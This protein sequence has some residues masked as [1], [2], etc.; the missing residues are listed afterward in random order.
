MQ[1]LF[2]VNGL[3]SYMH[4]CTSKTVHVEIL[5]IVRVSLV[6]KQKFWFMSFSHAVWRLF[7]LSVSFSFYWT[8]TFWSMSESRP[9]QMPAHMPPM[10]TPFLF[11][12]AK[13]IKLCVC[14]F[15]ST[16]E[17]QHQNHHREGL[18]GSQGTRASVCFIS[19]SL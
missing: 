11:T 7:S 19:R 10:F 1:W 2:T 18:W 3:S 4:I 14:G 8:F 6:E 13:Y 15:Q 16:S 12:D 5:I 9:T 17:E